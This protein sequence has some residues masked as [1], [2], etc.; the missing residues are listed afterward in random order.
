MDSSDTSRSTLG[1]RLQSLLHINPWSW[2]AAFY[3]I[4][5]L[6]S[7]VVMQMMGILFAEIALAVVFLIL[8][9]SIAIG[10]RWSDPSDRLGPWKWWVPVILYA[11]FIFSLSNNAYPE[12]VPRFDTKIFHPIEYMTL[13]IFLTM[14]WHKVSGHRG[15]PFV[16]L[17][18]LVS[19]VLFAVSDEY[20]QAFI[21]GRSPRAT[22]VLI[23]SLGLALGC[24][25]FLLGDRMIRRSKDEL[26]SPR[27]TGP[28]GRRSS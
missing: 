14:A 20:H 17:C 21:P 11:S 12:A 27:A 23:D 25:L 13:G 9:A 4:Q 19:G 8:G 3:V 7:L 16:I 15:N 22:D 6:G 24:I 2:I 28:D 26:Q 5:V 10:F 18:V 1:G